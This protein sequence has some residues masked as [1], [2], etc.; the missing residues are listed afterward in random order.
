MVELDIIK[1]IIDYEQLLDQISA[2]VMVRGEY[3]IPD[4]HPDVVEVLQV[5]AKS[6]ITNKEVQQERVYI[7]GKLDFNVSYLAKEDEGFGVRCV[8]WNDKFAHYVDLVGAEHRI[9]CDVECGI[10]HIDANIINE[11]KI[12]LETKTKIGCD[13]Y[14]AGDFEYVKEI[15]GSDDIEIKRKTEVFDKVIYKKNFEMSAKSN[16]KVPMDKSQIGNIIKCKVD[17]HKKEV[18]ISDGKI[19][20]SCYCK[21]ETIYRDL[22]SRELNILEDD[23]H[24]SQVEE[25]ENINI[26]MITTANFRISNVNYLVEKDDLGEDRILDIEML[27]D[28]DLKVVS[29]EHIEIIEDAYS[30]SRNMDLK[31]DIANISLL[32]DR[33]ISEYIVKDN[34]QIDPERGAPLQIIS[35]IGKIISLEKRINE[36][37]VLLDG[38]IGVDVLYKTSDEERGIGKVTGEIPFSTIIDVSKAK[39][40]MKALVKSWIDTIQANIEANTIGIKAIITSVV[41]VFKAFKK[42]YITAIEEKEGDMPNKRAS[43]TIYI[44]QKGDTIWDLAKRYNTTISELVNIND[45]ENVEDISVGE[46]IIIPGRAVLQ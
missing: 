46:K 22:D 33:G 5:D 18:K 38:I 32:V 44:V 40:G 41:D 28:G 14:D 25:I 19:E 43:L 1:E 23:V 10:E 8:N 11:R 13:V 17:L 2:D 36:G 35:T 31:K 9:V 6:I 27:V 12:S 21:I 37:K 15:E 7:E 39:E 16:L 30:P 20:L 29:K 24:V 42:A 34:I 45:F 4:T 3:L 26:D